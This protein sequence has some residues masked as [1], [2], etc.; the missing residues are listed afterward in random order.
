MNFTERF[1]GKMLKIPKDGITATM[2]KHDTP[3]EK[4]RTKIMKELN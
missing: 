1:H 2:S 3:V 4:S